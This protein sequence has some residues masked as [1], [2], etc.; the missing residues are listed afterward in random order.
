MPDVYRSCPVSVLSVWSALAQCSVEID[1][2]GKI[3]D[4]IKFFQ[5]LDELLDQYAEETLASWPQLN[6]EGFER[7]IRFHHEV[8]LGAIEIAES[9]DPSP[10]ASLL[11][12]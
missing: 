3:S 4:S 8:L 12:Q 10:I 2:W 6:P 11:I 5:R 1:A 7:E 9:D